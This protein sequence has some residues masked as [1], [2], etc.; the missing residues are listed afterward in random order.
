MCNLFRLFYKKGLIKMVEEYSVLR[1][2]A[3]NSGRESY[4]TD[5]NFETLWTNARTT[6]EDVI[7][8]LQK[9]M[10]NTKIT[11][12]TAF[13]C[14][15]GRALKITPVIEE[16]KV[17]FYFME[18]YGSNDLLQVMG[19][20]DAFKNFSLAAENVRKTMHDYARK[21]SYTVNTSNMINRSRYG[22]LCASSVNFMSL[23]RTLGRGGDEAHERVS[24]RLHN[25]AWWFAGV[26]GRS[27]ALIFEDEIDNELYAVTERNGFECA[28]VNLLINAYLHS[29]TPEGKKTY[30]KLSAYAKKG[31]LVVA[32]D[33]NGCKADPEYVSSFKEVYLKPPTPTGE[34]LGVALA[35]VYCERFGGELLFSVSPL[36][37]LRA[38]MHIPLGDPDR[39]LYFFADADEGRGYSAVRDTMRKG[40]TDQDIEGL[41]PW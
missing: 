17:R 16:K 25:I 21:L 2:I 27:G 29:A 22:R 30:V 36:G 31:D 32:V 1:D 28:V 38:E 9:P 19:A 20:T 41:I 40:F 24:D 11:R 26:A 10:L 37:G 23:L 33:D 34:G 4:I 7:K 35:Q 6:L 13:P 18:L 15:D 5:G 14:A 3:R 39:T 8:D 12:E